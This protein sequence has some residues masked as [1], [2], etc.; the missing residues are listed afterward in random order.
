MLSFRNESQY[1]AEL[2]CATQVIE[3]LAHT[4]N[5]TKINYYQMNATNCTYQ[6]GGLGHVVLA[7]ATPSACIGMLGSEPAIVLNYSA[8]DYSAV[9]AYRLYTYGNVQYMNSCAVA[10]DIS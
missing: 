8:T 7:N 9:T 1:V 4:R 3:V 10:V 6:V 5:A 2:N